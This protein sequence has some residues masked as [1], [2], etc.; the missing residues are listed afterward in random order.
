M[1]ERPPGIRRLCIAMEIDGDAGEIPGVL[2]PPRWRRDL[3]AVIEELGRVAALDR[4]HWNP[5]AV[6]GGE[7][8]F[9]PPGIDEGRFVAAFVDTLRSAIARLNDGVPRTERVRLRVALHQGIT[10]LDESGFSGR[11][12][13]KV[14]ALRDCAAL[15]AE[16]RRHPSVDLALAVSGELFDDVVEHDYPGLRGRD[17]RP[18]QVE[19][20]SGPG[21]DAWLLMPGLTRATARLAAAAATRDAAA[22]RRPEPA[23]RAARSPLFAIVSTPAGSWPVH[24]R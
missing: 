14:A 11:A 17:F 7:I 12:V 23:R 22:D 13:V 5:P 18:E 3:G 1:S 6:G 9:L 4:A 20:E 10:F 15:R 19:L 16:L 2:R 21:V 24:V 8:A